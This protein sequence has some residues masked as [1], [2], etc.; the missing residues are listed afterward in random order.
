[1]KALMKDLEAKNASPGAGA[2]TL[3]QLEASLAAA[4]ALLERWQ[5]TATLRMGMP[6]GES[7]RESSFRSQA[8]R[9]GSDL[10]K[11]CDLPN[12]SR[13]TGAHKEARWT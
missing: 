5:Q 13:T 10:W 8:E 3:S 6:S 4:T 7:A 2:L 11:A 9:S 1:M 12:R